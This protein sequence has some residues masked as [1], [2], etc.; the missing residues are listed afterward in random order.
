MFLASVERAGLSCLL[1]QTSMLAHSVLFKREAKDILGPGLACSS[2]CHRVWDLPFQVLCYANREARGP[3][4]QPPST[5]IPGFA[6]HP[7]L[8]GGEKVP[9]GSTRVRV[10]LHSSFQVPG[11]FTPCLGSLPSTG[12]TH[13]GFILAQFWLLWASLSAAQIREKIST[14]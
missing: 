11:K 4:A 2:C 12:E 1:K 7:T 5:F 10:Q 3:V 14:F 6:P 13:I 8:S 9:C